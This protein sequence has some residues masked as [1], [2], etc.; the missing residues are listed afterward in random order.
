MVIGKAW[1]KDGISK[2][3]AWRCESSHPS[4]SGGPDGEMRDGGRADLADEGKGDEDD[5]IGETD[6][7]PEDAE[8]GLGGDR[9]AVDPGDVVEEAVGAVGPADADH[10][11]DGFQRI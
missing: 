2:D 1:R 9:G 10:L 8:E 5:R 4:Q 11:G 6:A 7:L 3:D